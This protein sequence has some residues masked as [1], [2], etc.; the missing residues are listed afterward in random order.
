MPAPRNDKQTDVAALAA[1]VVAVA[2]SM[3]IA[4]GP[5]DLLG[6]IVAVTMAL[7]I[8]GYVWPNPRKKMESVALGALAGIVLIPI[9]CYGWE[10]VATWLEGR[11]FDRCGQPATWVPE[12]FPATV[13]IVG[14]L[15]IA[16]WD[17]RRW[18]P[19]AIE[20]GARDQDPPA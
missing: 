12:W 11:R 17:C 8:R 9:F 3:F 13:W 4:P 14:I 10:L 6:A 20:T 1:G 2:V 19:P 18:N 7:I 15:L 16:M 5:Y